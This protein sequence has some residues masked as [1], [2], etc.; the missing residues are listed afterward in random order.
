MNHRHRNFYQ[1]AAVLRGAT[2]HAPPPSPSKLGLS[3]IAQ[4]PGVL[5]GA[6]PPVVRH[7]QGTGTVRRS[8]G[9][10]R[11]RPR[12]IGRELRL[13][14]RLPACSVVKVI[15]RRPSAATLRH[16]TAAWLPPQ[17]YQRSAS[18]LPADLVRRLFRRLDLLTLM[19]GWPSKTERREM[20]AGRSPTSAGRRRRS[21]G[22]Q[23]RETGRWWRAQVDSGQTMVGTGRTVA[24]VG[25]TLAGAGR[26][27]AG[28]GQ[29]ANDAGQSPTGGGQSMGDTGRS[30][31]AAGRTSFDEENWT[32][33]ACGP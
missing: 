21:S 28:V 6:H 5:P 33:V 2:T 14:G 7:A 19:A 12:T 27:I 8:Y 32:L 4:S 17:Y 13:D 30:T 26:W 16:N 10:L 29:S 1:V 15:H 22:R 23:R 18:P 24:G 31:A 9:P 3:R 11:D 25:R 20:S